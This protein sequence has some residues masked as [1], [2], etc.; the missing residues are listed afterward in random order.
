MSHSYQLLAGMVEHGHDGVLV[1]PGGLGDGLDVAL[2]DDDGPRGDELPAGVGGAQVGGHAGRDD[3]AA[4]GVGEA[5]DE[6]GALAGRPDARRVG[7]EDEVAVEV[8]D[9][10]VGWGLEERTALGGD[11]KDGGTG[12]VDEGLNV[13]GMDDGDVEAGP[14][15]DAQGEAHGLGGQGEHGRVVADEDEAAGGLDG[16][17]EHANEVGDGQTVEEGPEGEVLEARGG[18]GELVAEGIVLHVDAHQVVEARGGEAE[19]ARDLLGV[20]EVGGL[21]PVDPH[22]AQVVAEQVVERVAR[23]EAEAVGDP[24]A[25]IGR[26]VQVRVGLAA[27]IADGVGALVVGARPDAQGDAVQGV[28]RV[29]LQD[30]GVVDAMGLRFAG[31]YFDVMREAGLVEL[32]YR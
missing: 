32:V 23:Q 7:G 1:P 21:V 10:G 6:L 8:D 13:A 9:E 16:G 28:G 18:R 15:V 4:Q 20:E 5:L 25:V 22:A 3:L 24:V 17:L 12:L 11:A 30:E 27:Q 26:V 2:H 19:D 31:A 29:L 14:L